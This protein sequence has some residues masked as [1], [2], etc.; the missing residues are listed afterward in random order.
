M[1]LTAEDLRNFIQL[2]KLVHTAAGITRLNFTMLW[3]VTPC[4]LIT[5]FTLKMVAAGSSEMLVRAYETSRLHPP[6]RPQFMLH[7]HVSVA[8]IDTD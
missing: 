8:G 6:G 2:A 7:W 3:G 1:A 4:S 5:P